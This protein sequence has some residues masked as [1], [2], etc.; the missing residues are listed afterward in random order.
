MNVPC[1][2]EEIDQWTA[3]VA[4]VFGTISIISKSFQRSK[5]ALY[6]YFSLEQGRLKMLKTI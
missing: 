4:T 6:I 1:S 2:F 5:Q 3:V